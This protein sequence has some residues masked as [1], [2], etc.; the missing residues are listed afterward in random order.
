MS[1]ST[2]ADAAQQ[3][4]ELQ[5]YALL[6]DDWVPFCPLQYV[7]NVFILLSSLLELPAYLTDVVQIA[8]NGPKQ[9]TSGRRL[10]T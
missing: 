1:L 8:T 3:H 6:D 4:Q 5:A 10:H 2:S 7:S 9:T